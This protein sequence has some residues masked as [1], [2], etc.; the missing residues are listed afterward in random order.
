MGTPLGTFAD[1]AALDSA[2]AA[3]GDGSSP[4]SAQVDMGT[5]APAVTW[6]TQANPVV[7]MPGIY[8]T[9]DD[10]V[11]LTVW[12]STPGL[13]SLT[14]VLRILRP[15]GTII[16]TPLTLSNLPSD[17]SANVATIGQI[18][19]FLVGAVIAPPSVVVSRGRTFINLSVQRGTPQNPIA[20]L[21]LLTDYVH[22]GFQPGWPVGRLLSSVEGSGYVRQLAGSVPLAGNDATL[23][24]SARTQWRLMAL[25]AQLTTSAVAGTRQVGCT[26]V[27]GGSVLYIGFAGA[28]QGPSLVANY[29]FAAGVP[30]MSGQPLNQA[31]PIPDSLLLAPGSVFNTNTIGLKAAD[32]WTAIAATVEEWIDV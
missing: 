29:S 12:N 25:I 17:R 27:I 7:S 26:V 20:S 19:G 22:T 3:S 11:A 1:L 8:L 21:V 9:L 31:I 28:T 14:A 23:A 4:A 15:D 30:L 32:Q 2:A 18:E 5:Q 6:N 13:S 24:I 10:S 16:L